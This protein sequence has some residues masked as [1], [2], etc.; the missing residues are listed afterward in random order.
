MPR[1][2]NR[3][4]GRGRPSALAKFSSG[5]LMAELDRRRSMV[6]HFENQRAELQAQLI[7]LDSEIARYGGNGELS[8]VVKVAGLKR[9]RRAQRDGSLASVLHSL[10]KGKTMAVADMV[11]AAKRAGYRSKSKNFRAVVSLTLL[12]NARMFK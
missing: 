11:E 10:I 3:T 7:A 9:G 12:K 1:K 8:E 2:K 5:Q 6:A 4:G